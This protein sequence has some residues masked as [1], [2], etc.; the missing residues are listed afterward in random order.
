M[1]AST[2]SVSRSAGLALRIAWLR[3]APLPASPVPN[4]LSRTERRSRYGSRMML[5]TR[6]RSTCLPVCETGRGCCPAPGWPFGT[7]ASGGRRALA[8]DRH[9]GGAHDGG[10]DG[11]DAPH[12]PGSTRLGLQS[13]EPLESRHGFDPSVPGCV[14]APGHRARLPV[15][16]PWNGLAFGPCGLGV[17]TP[18]LGVSVKLKA[19]MIGWMRA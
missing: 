14:A 18:P 6:S 9:G 7:V 16:R 8:D 19:L 4:S 3:A 1:M 17:S 2:R 5:L 11:G 10:E 12:G 13:G 15:V